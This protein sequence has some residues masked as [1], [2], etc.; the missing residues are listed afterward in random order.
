MSAR[1]LIKRLTVDWRDLDWVS[2]AGVAVIVVFI[3]VLFPAALQLNTDL[4]WLRRSGVIQ[5]LRDFGVVRP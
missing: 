1:R 2:I 5:T 4:N 3:T